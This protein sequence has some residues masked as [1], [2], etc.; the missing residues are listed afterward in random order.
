MSFIFLPETVE[1][2]PHWAVG[3]VE[4]TVTPQQRGRVR[5]MATTWFARFYQSDAQATALPG[6]AVKV[7]GREGLT[8]LIVPIG[9]ST[10][11]HELQLNSKRQRKGK[12][13]WERD[14]A[15]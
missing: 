9:D 8:L 3:D 1:F 5:F 2:F 6:T 12:V 14:A 13:W 10:H 4:Q 7:I 15:T 11:Q